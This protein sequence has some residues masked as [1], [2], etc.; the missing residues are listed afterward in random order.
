MNEGDLNSNNPGTCARDNGG[1]VKFSLVPMHLLAG[2]ARVLMH[3]E[4]KY[5]AWNWAKG[6]KWSQSFDCC[7]RHML[8]FWYC[9]KDSD[10]ES[11]LHHIDHAICNLLFLRHNIL[12]Y[13]AGDDRPPVHT[14]MEGEVDWVGELFP[15]RDEEDK[16]KTYRYWVDN[17]GRKYSAC[18]LSGRFTTPQGFSEDK[19]R[20][21]ACPTSAEVKDAQVKDRSV[22]LKHRTD[23]YFTDRHGYDGGYH[24]EGGI[25]ETNEEKENDNE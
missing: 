11:T 23:L 9:R 4:K 16:T 6:G 19:E 10:D 20:V 15:N 25:T 1:K 22:Q 18:S 5:K 14:M 13:P 17:D 24:H 21:Q 8:K 2:V 7:M 12:S 3:G